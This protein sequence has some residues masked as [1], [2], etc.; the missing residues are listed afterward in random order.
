MK[1]RLNRFVVF[2]CCAVVML[3]IGVTISGE[4]KR[5]RILFLSWNVESGGNDPAAIAT[6]R[7]RRV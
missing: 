1:A 7:L 2:T 6:R 3:A 5:T 4:Y